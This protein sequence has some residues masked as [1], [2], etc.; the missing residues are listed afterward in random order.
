MET[1]LGLIYPTSY[2]YLFYFV[3]IAFSDIVKYKSTGAQIFK[4]GEVNR[5]PEQT[6]YSICCS[7]WHWILDYAAMLLSHRGFLALTKPLA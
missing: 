1:A 2:V 5:Q 6:S 4:S 7:V 3:L